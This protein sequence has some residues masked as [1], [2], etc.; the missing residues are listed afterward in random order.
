M[1]LASAA[2]ARRAAVAS[3][4]RRHR[5]PSPT[6]TT[7]ARA[8]TISRFL[9]TTL[10]SPVGNGSAAAPAAARAL[11]TPRPEGGP[12]PQASR[13][14]IRVSI[15]AALAAL[16]P[17]LLL[18]AAAPATTSPVPPAEWPQLRGPRGDGTADA[19]GLLPSW[20]NGGPRELWRRPIGEGFSSVA[21]SGDH[22]YTMGL[23]GEQEAVFC[24]RITDGEL[25]WKT[26]IGPKFSE[27][28]GN[29]PRS[30]PAVGGERV[31][32]LSATGKLAA[33]RTRDGG[34]VW[35][36]DLVADMAGRVPLR[37]YAPSPVL[38][39]G[40][41]LL[42]VGGAEAK[43][44]VAFDAATGAPRWTALD[45][46]PGYSTPIVVSID[47]VKQYVF[48]HTAGADVVALLP[49]GS[50]HWKH[51]WPHG[52]IAMPVFV[53]P[54]RI[55]VSTANDVGAVL[56]EVTH[57]GGKATVREVWASR[58]MKNHFNT[59]VYHQGHLFGFDNATFKALDVATGKTRWAQRGFGKGTV[60]LAGDLLLVL[61]D[62]GVLALVEA[63]AEAYRELGRVQAMTGKSWTSPALAGGRIVLRDQDEI[64]A[65]DLR[66]A[67][68]AAGAE[69]AATAAAGGGTGAPR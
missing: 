47:G 34:K 58:E 51:P 35:E 2:L 1:A 63:S 10:Q 19:T 41:L 46:R 13:F 20:Q 30:T 5:T 33:L 64:V 52:P 61:S 23:D 9:R 37:G 62:R 66:T 54:N 8:K 25:V 31:Y 22:L 7:V 32:A 11:R 28:F 42:E 38:D 15:T 48:A 65:Y 67:A 29:G 14:T 43:S 44:V 27:E 49:D 53:P 69:P 36:R 18:A 55:F 26:P 40:L 39:G 6:V 60:L 12:M 16:A 21:V 50:V 59:T 68:P 45:N 3:A 24:L 4:L 57:A 56:L 17:T